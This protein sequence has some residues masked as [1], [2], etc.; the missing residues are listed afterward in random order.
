MS[1]SAFREKT[2]ADFEESL[3]FVEDINFSQLHVF[4][5]SPRRGTPRSGL[6]GSRTAARLRRTEQ[7]DDFVG[8]ATWC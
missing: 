2:E 6:R 3:Q 4:R 7:S 1:W 8:K 5:Y